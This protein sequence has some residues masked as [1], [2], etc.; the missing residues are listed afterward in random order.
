MLAFTLGIGQLII[1]INKMDTVEYDETRFKEIQEATT[2]FIT[3]IGY[4][5]KSVVPIV[6]IS[7]LYGD[8]IKEV[9]GKSLIEAIDSVQIPPLPVEKPLRL[10]VQDVHRIGGIGTMPVGRVEA[11]MIK[12]GMIVEFCPPGITAEVK[13]V[14]VHDEWVSEGV[15]GDNVGFNVKNVSVKDI[16]RGNVVGAAANTPPRE[17]A[18][19]IAEMIILNHPDQIKAGYTPTLDCHTAHVACKFDQLM[20]KIDARTGKSIEHFPESISSGDAAVV[21]IVPQKP[22]CVEAFADYPALGRF[23]IRDA[24]Q[25]V[26]IGVIKAVATVD[27]AKKLARK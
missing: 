5:H 2:K 23:T 6:P 22:I 27:R 3:S 1:A 15:P 13:H 20:E 8:N 10:P 12:P 18:S 19:F 25:T 7:G 4:N 9:S 24:R 14:E 11:G 16:C 21:R 26:A 17:A